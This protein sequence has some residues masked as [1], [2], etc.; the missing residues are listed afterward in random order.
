M[1]IFIDGEKSSHDIDSEHRFDICQRP[2]FFDQKNE[3]STTTCINSPA[4][5]SEITELTWNSL[6]I[7]VV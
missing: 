1:D 6:Q 7:I 4:L 5:E 2:V 3:M